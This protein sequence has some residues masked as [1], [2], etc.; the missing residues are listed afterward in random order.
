MKKFGF[1]LFWCSQFSTLMYMI[2]L[3]CVFIT[4][5][6][7]H[8]TSDY[9]VTR[10]DPSSLCYVK[11]PVRFGLQMAIFKEPQQLQ[12]KGTYIHIYI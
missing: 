5:T 4:H 2:A 1:N 7:I 3:Y 10:K 12:R 8:Q 6:L 11:T 9:T